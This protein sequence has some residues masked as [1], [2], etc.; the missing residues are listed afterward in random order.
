VNVC[1]F[2]VIDFGQSIEEYNMFVTLEY[3]LFIV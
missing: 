2:I 3:S 1:L